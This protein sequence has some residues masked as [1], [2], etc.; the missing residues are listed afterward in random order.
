MRWS[1][2][3]ALA[4]AAAGPTPAVASPASV[5]PREEAEPVL[6]LPDYI[7][8]GAETTWKLD[9]SKSNRTSGRFQKLEILLSAQSR[10]NKVNG[11][12]RLERYCVLAPCIRMNVTST[13]LTI[14]KDAFP[15]YTHIVP[16]VRY[17]ESDED[18]WGVWSGADTSFGLLESDGAWSNYEKAWG[19]G[20][21]GVGLPC[22]ALS[23]ARSCMIRHFDAKVDNQSRERRQ[24]YELCVREKC[25]VE[26]ARG[27]TLGAKC[28]ETNS[29]VP[30]PPQSPAENDYAQGKGGQGLSTSRYLKMGYTLPLA[31]GTLGVVYAFLV[32][33]LRLTQ[34]A[35]EPPTLATTIPFISSAVGLGSGTQKFFVK[36]RDKYNYP[37]YTLR[38]PGSRIYVVNSL[39]LIQSIQRQIKSIAFSPMEARA[40]ENVMGIGPAGMAIIDSDNM[41]EE[42]SYLSTFI[43][44]TH[45]AMSPGQGLDALNEA[46]IRSIST[47]L[48]DVSNR[49]PTTVELFAWIRR[50][51]YFA[52][53]DSIYGPK[54]PVRD[55]ALESAW[56]D[57]EPTI[58]I[59]MLN[60][61]PSILARKGQRAREE[62]LVPAF[63]K[64][65][66]EEGHLQG[67]LL[68]QCRREHNLQH[69]VNGRDLAAT[70]IGNMIASLTNSM[71][72]AFWMVYH[73]YSH[74]E[75]LEECRKEVEQ[76][77]Q[78]DDNGICT[79]DLAKVKTSCPV[80]LSTWQ[81]T[82]RY[83]HIGISARLVM[84]DIMLDNKYLLKKGATVMSAPIIQHTD[85]SAWGP[86]ANHFDHRRFLRQDDGK[87]RNPAVFRAFGGGTILC[88]GRHFVTTEVMSLAAMLL[89]RF[90]L[91]PATKDGR[92]PEP[93]KSFPMT[94]A[95]PVPKD[96]VRVQVVPR[97]K[98]QWRVDFS[99]SNKGVDMVVE[100]A[101]IH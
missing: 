74:V 97:D 21:H 67:S 37:I 22:E 77:V 63:E 81:E 44:S 58:M 91:K 56:Y 8:A 84:Q 16:E 99:R 19:F 66:A 15:L 7:R 14:P 23:C 33:L 92:W 98:R 78:T 88:P 40:A 1:V 3:A 86:T 72:S 85:Q 94:A 101:V 28:I 48:T 20:P 50:Q 45:P 34:D 62:L 38:L 61:F 57:F 64:Y 95:M 10:E 39:P 53:T 75:A 17:Y 18:R 60:A 25:G 96:E 42:G 6:Q 87:R 43:P 49:G 54:N 41:L 93:R 100:D 13:I 12:Y 51:L 36:L 55:P 29:K 11:F 52:T 65:F 68:V 76:L 27:Q 30:E 46:A 35:R 69:G 73:L 31:L 80:L 4:A 9:L 5:M 47:S 90:D 70:E 83:M 24:Q 89:L 59:H 71:A 79:I 26:A 82:L 2:F 32:A